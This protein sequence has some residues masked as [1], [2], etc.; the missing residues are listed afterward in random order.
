[1]QNMKLK[2]NV[3]A[4]GV[5]L[6]NHNETIVGQAKKGLAVRTS[7]KAGGLAG[8]NHNETIVRKPRQAR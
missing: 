5:R 6:G 3:K 8:T 7:V 2:T 1:M 4:G